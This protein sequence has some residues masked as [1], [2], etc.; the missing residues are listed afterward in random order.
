MNTTNEPIVKMGK[1]ELKQLVNQV[2]ET[3]DANHT[4]QSFSAADLWN[5]QKQYKTAKRLHTKWI[6]N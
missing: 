4:K 6:L 3:V 1:D 5:I 2:N